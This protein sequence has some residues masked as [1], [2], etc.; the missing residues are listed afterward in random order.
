MDEERTNGWDAIGLLVDASDLPAFG[1]LKLIL[2]RQRYFPSSPSH[3]QASPLQ[4]KLP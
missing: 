1:S 2:G 4:M 3:R